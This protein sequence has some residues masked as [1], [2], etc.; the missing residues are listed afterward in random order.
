MARLL[1][2]VVFSAFVSVA[3]CAA[4]GSD[5]AASA[6]QQ[7]TTGAPSNAHSWRDGLF[8]SGNTMGT[9]L[10]LRWQSVR[11]CNTDGTNC[12]TEQDVLDLVDVEIF[13]YPDRPFIKVSEAEVA[14]FPIEDDG[15]FSISTERTEPNGAMLTHLVAGKISYPATVTIQLF[16]MKSQAP[17]QVVFSDRSFIGAVSGVLR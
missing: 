6:V 5:D 17:H 14:S 2:P 10:D 1:L 12:H 13:S 8:T 7:D 9:T 3:G 4:P 16:E 15:S 11:N